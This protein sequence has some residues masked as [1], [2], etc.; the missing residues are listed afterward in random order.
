MR[1]KNGD[2]VDV[3]PDQHRLDL[4]VDLLTRDDA[5]AAREV[6]EAGGMKAETGIPLEPAPLAGPSQL[7]FMQLTL[8]DLLTNK[9]LF[10]NTDSHDRQQWALGNGFY[11]Y[12]EQCIQCNK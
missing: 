7:R 8:L 1:D 9:E 10:S 3:T 6:L 2:I 12:L 11:Q 4:G 5:K